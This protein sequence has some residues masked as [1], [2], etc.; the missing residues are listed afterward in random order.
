MYIFIFQEQGACFFSGE[1]FASAE[2]LRAAFPGFFLPASSSQSHT[3]QSPS[4]HSTSQL[5]TTPKSPPGD[6]AAL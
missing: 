4:T 2:S 1:F 6:W 5:H 3:A